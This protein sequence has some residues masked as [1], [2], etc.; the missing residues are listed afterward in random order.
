MEKYLPF[1]IEPN[2]IKIP[3]KTSQEFSIIFA[4][5]REFEGEVLAE[6]QQNHCRSDNFHVKIVAKT[7]SLPYWFNL[8]VS[9]YLKSHPEQFLQYEN[10]IKTNERTETVEFEIVGINNA[11]KR[12][13]LV[14]NSS[15]Q[16]IE[17]KMINLEKMPQFSSFTCSTPN[18]I[19]GP[20]KENLI[21]FTFKPI[22]FGVHEGCFEFRTEN[23][24]NC[25]ILLKGLARESKITFDNIILTLPTTVCG[26]I[27]SN[28][29]IIQNNDI[30][31]VHFSFVK[32]TLLQNNNLLCVKPMFATLE[33]NSEQKIV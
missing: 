4:P 21:E 29:L 28:T 26:R 24:G 17:Y 31:S 19:I 14:H 9:S 11:L 7:K 6:I 27:T 33:P 18:G 3:P 23:Y 22:E 25:L 12:N 1:R 15:S 30:V 20:N 8:P 13:F 16:E 2:S 10:Y 5:L 32:E